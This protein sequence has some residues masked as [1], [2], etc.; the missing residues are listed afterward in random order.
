MF[1]LSTELEYE[2]ANRISNMVPA[3]E[4]V[5][6]SNSGTEAVMFAVPDAGSRKLAT[7]PSPGTPSLAVPAITQLPAVFQEPDSELKMCSGRRF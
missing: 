6:F 3:A 1:A 5:R 2:V 7:A 4:L